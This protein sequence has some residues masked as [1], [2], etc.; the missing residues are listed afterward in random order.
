MT[1]ITDLNEIKKIELNVLIEVAKLC[2]EQGLRYWLAGGTLIGAIRHHGF[3]PWDDDIDIA[4]PRSDYMKLIAYCK[5]N[6]T[7][8]DLFAHE[9]ND[10]HFRLFAKACSKDTI[11]EE[12]DGRYSLC[13]TGIWVDIFPLDGLGNSYTGALRIAKKHKHDQYL[14]TASLWKKY[15]RGERS[16]FR[17]PYRFVFYLMGKFVNK[18]KLIQK[19]ENRYIFND[20][21]TSKYCAPVCGSY[22]EKEIVEQELFKNSI[23]VEFEGHMFKAPA[24]YDRY[25]TLLYGD[26][27]QL[28]PEEKRVGHHTFTA[29]YKE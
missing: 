25:L 13:P 16:I 23:D 19:M 7:P 28:P 21:D 10:G 29:Y 20:F 27:M 24:G 15:F 18:R 2:E 4:M 22:A 6:E 9:I 5:E 26:Y 12:N 3:I 8:F 11:V 14:L 17:E 1:Q